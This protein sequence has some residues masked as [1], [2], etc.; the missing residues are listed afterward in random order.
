MSQPT[1]MASDHDIMITHTCMHIHTHKETSQ[2]TR[3][4]VFV[5]KG[6]GIMSR[7]SERR[8]R[9]R[10]EIR[11]GRRIWLPKSLSRD[12]ILTPTECATKETS[13]L[14]EHSHFDAPG[15]ERN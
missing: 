7:I 4:D 14:T 13:L 1:Q 11:H 10:R 15:K 9:D 5:S 12:M 8:T 3:W 6:K 2:H